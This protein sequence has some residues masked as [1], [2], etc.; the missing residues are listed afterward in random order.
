MTLTTCVYIECGRFILALTLAFIPSV[1]RAA[2]GDVLGVFRFR[3]EL[4]S[5]DQYVNMVM[6]YQTFRFKN[7]N[8]VDSLRFNINLT[9]F[10]PELFSITIRCLC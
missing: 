6:Q 1:H 7:L 5:V 2:F 3:H 8:I 4:V 10:Q 9:F